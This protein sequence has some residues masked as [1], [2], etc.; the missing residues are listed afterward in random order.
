MDISK[1]QNSEDSL[2]RLAAQRYLYSKAKKIRN[3]KLALACFLVLL[4][5]I[6]ILFYSISATVL[7]VI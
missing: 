1:K 7:G 3:Y 6:I 2:K 5:P 4:S